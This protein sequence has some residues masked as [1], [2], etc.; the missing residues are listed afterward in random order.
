VS[1]TVPWAASDAIGRLTA[2]QSLYLSGTHVADLG[3]LKG[4]TA[5]QSLHLSGTPDVGLGPVQDLPNLKAISGAPDAEKRRFDA[6]RA[7]KGLPPIA[8]KF[9]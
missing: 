2:L 7:Q 5:L 1:R 8:D 4:L 9:Q 3:P 6:Y